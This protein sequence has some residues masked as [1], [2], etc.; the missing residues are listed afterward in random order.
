MARASKSARSPR[1]AFLDAKESRG[2]IR[3]YFEMV[4]MKKKSSR[5]LAWQFTDEQEY[6]ISESSVY[7]ILKSFDLVQS[8]AFLMVTARDKFEN[9]TTEVNK[10][11]QT[12]FTYFKIIDWGWHYLS[13]ILD[14]FS[15]YIFLTHYRIREPG[16]KNID[17]ALLPRYQIHIFCGYNLTDNNRRYNTFQP[18]VF[19]C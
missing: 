9:P 11:W 18:A 2:K 19:S 13:T 16:M 8:P 6:F 10:L 1:G 7:R 5:Q 12:D 15:R 4:A 14:D 17:P 3:P